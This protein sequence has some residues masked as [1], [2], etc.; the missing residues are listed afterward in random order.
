[1]FKLPEKVKKDTE[2]YRNS[3]HNLI[4]G[5]VSLAYFKGIR[6]PW[7]F[8]SHRGGK[9]FMARIRIPAGIVNSSQLKALAFASKKYGKGILHITTRQD[10]QIHDVKLEDTIG[11]LDYLKE[12]DLSSRGGGGNTVRNIIACPLSGICKDEM[13]DVRV[14]ILT[15]RKN[16]GSS[17]D[18]I[19]DRLEMIMTTVQ[20]FL[21][22]RKKFICLSDPGSN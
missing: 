4:E 1:M 11:I 7:G 20:S 14:S 22:L 21:C 10:I 5:N 15:Y 9:S 8:Y 6:V 17:D 3:L 13:F 19:K 16:R 18:A 2:S 12:Y